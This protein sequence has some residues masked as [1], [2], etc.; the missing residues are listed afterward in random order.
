[1]LTKVTRADDRR[2]ARP[3][4]KA[5]DLRSLGS[6]GRL[7]RRTHPGR[8]ARDLGAELI[9][10]IGGN[11]TVTQR[12]LIERTIKMNL[13][14]DALD[15]KLERGE[16]TA[17]DQRTYGALNNALR[18]ALRELEGMGPRTRNKK[19]GP[20]LDELIAGHRRPA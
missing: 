20:D 16:W 7:D 11:P 18:L 5:L 8:L 6:L 1:V 13:Q 12:L 9:E 3:Y 2:L 17:N 10:H 4:A 14:L 19:K 15:A